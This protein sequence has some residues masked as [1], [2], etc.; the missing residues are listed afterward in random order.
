MELSS[1]PYS[2]RDIIPGAFTAKDTVTG[3]L[4]GDALCSR[5]CHSADP[6]TAQNTPCDDLPGDLAGVSKDLHVSEAVTLSVGE[7]V[8]LGRCAKRGHARRLAYWIW[9]CMAFE[10]ADDGLEKLGF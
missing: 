3:A 1:E 8:K 4:Q 6:V 5:S 10:D 7:S 9:D 2:G